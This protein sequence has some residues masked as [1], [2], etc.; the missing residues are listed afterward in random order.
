MK[1]DSILKTIKQ[2][3]ATPQLASLATLTEQGKPWS[4]YVMIVTD[5]DL[6]MR[7]ATFIHARKVHQINHNN[8]VHLNCGISDPN[9]M[10]PY[11]QIQGKAAFTNSK[12]ERH[13]LWN[14]HLAAIFQGHDDP[15]YG[16]IVIKPY[17]I[18]LMEA[19]SFEPKVWKE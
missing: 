9:K 2:M 3:L 12:E 16:V 15:N 18:E 5:G 8:E 6:T 4:R 14:E 10:A 7:C 19:G 1:T 17:R 11:L 13:A